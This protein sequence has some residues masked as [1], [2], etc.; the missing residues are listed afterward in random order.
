M[1]GQTISHYRII[2]KLRDG[3]MGVVYRAQ[4][5]RL[6]RML[7]MPVTR[8][9]EVVNGRRGITA[10]TALRLA[11]HFGTTLEFG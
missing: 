11:R 9:S 1:T 7:R 5:V 4:D 10:D 8:V 2:E 3:G 6:G